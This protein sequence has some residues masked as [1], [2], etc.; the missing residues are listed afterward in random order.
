MT[1]YR[2]LRDNKETG[3]FSE[4]EMIAKGFKP[5]DLIW[6]EGRSAGWRYPSEIPAFKNFAP[7]IEEQPYDRFYKKQPPQKLFALEE[8]NTAPNYQAA[9]YAPVAKTNETVQPQSTPVK[10]IPQTL[11]AYSAAQPTIQT[12]PGRHIHVTLP[13]GNTVNLTTVVAKKE[14]KEIKNTIDINQVPAYLPSVQ[15]AAIE[16]V[17]PINRGSFYEPVKN[18]DNT[19]PEPAVYAAPV[20]INQPSQTGFSW[21]LIAAAC[22]GIATLVGLGI[23][24][25]LAISRDKNE[26]VFNE[27]LRSKSRQV[28]SQGTSNTKSPVTGATAETPGSIAG[29]Q[30][31]QQPAAGNKELVQN[32]VVKTTVAPEN[33]YSK[34]KK[35]AEE[36]SVGTKDKGITNPE[37]TGLHIKPVPAI[38]NVEKS[39]SLTANDFKTGAFGGIS[40]LKY[41]L[42]NGSKFT[43]ESVEVEVDYVQANNKVFK[44]ERLS[45]SNVLAGTQVTI[46]APAS[47]RGVKMLSRIIKV[48]AKDTALTNTTAKS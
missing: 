38:I 22:I 35:T 41:T 25:G 26:M 8:K 14:N 31:L 46:D 13:S 34:D 37:E 40:G 16:P 33:N 19:F 36:K 48:S 18:V 28:Q 6:V 2:L 39:L 43:L 17:Y 23:M 42:F 7:V 30:P 21:S 11:P 32:A 9:A 27:T 44:T 1:H 4:D 20:Y 5:Y 15:P 12:L 45:F 10:S 47:N 24:I 3:P 29:E